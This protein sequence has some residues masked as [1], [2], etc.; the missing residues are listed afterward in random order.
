MLIYNDDVVHVENPAAN[1]YYGNSAVAIV[2]FQESHREW[3]A[4]GIS[5]EIVQESV[6]VYYLQQD[7]R[8]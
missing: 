3:A 1:V 4:T 6:F 7:A 2:C 8:R 5:S